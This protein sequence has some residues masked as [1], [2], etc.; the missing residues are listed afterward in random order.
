MN[1]QEANALART[2]TA[3]ADPTRVQLVAQLAHGEASVKEL[4][5]PFDMS[6]QAV[7]RHLKVLEEVGLVS[8]RKA[9]QSRP[10]RL[11][12]DRLVEVLA[13]VDAQRRAWVDRHKRLDDHL[14]SLTTEPS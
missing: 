7:S 1:T 10:A 4:S 11:E 9:A 14:R 13:W 2:F 6:Q 12:V 5:E 3:L 8:R